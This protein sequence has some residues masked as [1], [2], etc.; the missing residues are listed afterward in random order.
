MI[1]SSN[2]PDLGATPPRQPGTVLVAAVDV[3]W[4]KNYRIRGGNMPFCYSVVWI[5]LVTACG[6]QPCL[7]EPSFWYPR[8]TCMTRRKPRTLISQA[9]ARP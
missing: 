1:V 6:S 2:L 7:G 8:P 3:E 5:A 4:S 9:E